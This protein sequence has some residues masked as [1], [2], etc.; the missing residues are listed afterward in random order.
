M[1]VWGGRMTWRNPARALCTVPTA[2]P[3]AGLALSITAR[4][5]FRS[6][7]P[8]RTGKFDLPTPSTRLLPELAFIVSDSHLWEPASWSNRSGLV[9]DT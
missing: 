4:S 8:L 2:T 3:Q 6:S 9:S 5:A 7:T 1:G